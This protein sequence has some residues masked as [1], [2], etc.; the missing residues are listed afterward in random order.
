MVKEHYNAES[1]GGYSVAPHTAK[2][3]FPAEEWIRLPKPRS[4][5]WGL[6]RTTLLEMCDRGEIKSTVIKKKHA[7]RGIRLIYL[8]SLQAALEKFSDGGACENQ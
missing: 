7:M 4:R 1:N 2:A 3:A 5:F 8:P 6:S